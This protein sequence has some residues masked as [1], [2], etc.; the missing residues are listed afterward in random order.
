MSDEKQASFNMDRSIVA[1]V[2]RAIDEGAAYATSRSG[3]FRACI[4]GNLRVTE[5]LSRETL[6]Y[7]WAEKQLYIELIQLA[8]PWKLRNTVQ[9]MGGIDRLLE[10]HDE[11]DKHVNN[12]LRHALRSALHVQFKI[13][14][15][16]WETR[17]PGPK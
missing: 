4:E 8:A 11:V 9:A 10:I 1:R 6:A 2:D 5:S 7:K 13:P 12:D 14:A 3:Y 17:A 16:A 15:D